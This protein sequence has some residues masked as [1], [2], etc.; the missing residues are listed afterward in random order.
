MQFGGQVL[1]A[2]AA[3]EQGEADKKILAHNMILAKQNAKAVELKGKFDQ[4]MHWKSA[5]KYM[6]SLTAKLGASG[7]MLEEGVTADIVNEQ[8]SNFSLD[9]AMIGYNAYI[10][11]ERSRNMISMFGSQKKIAGMRAGNAELG[12]YFGAA[13]TGASGTG[14]IM[15]QYV[16]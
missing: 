4:R 15:Q 12:A 14:S 6:S 11:A 13:G 1:G 5:M 16:A 8:L 3:K 7:A 9:N 10:E 2:L